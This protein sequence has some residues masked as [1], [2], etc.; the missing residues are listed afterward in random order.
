V[1]GIVAAA[2]LYSTLIGIPVA[3]CVILFVQIQLDPNLGLGEI[4]G[5]F[6]ADRNSPIWACYE[7]LIH[8]AWLSGHKA[9]LYWMVPLASA[10]LLIPSYFVSVWLEGRVC[11]HAWRQIE[12]GVVSA[13]VT[14]VNRLSYAALFLCACGWLGW[15]L[16][17]H[18]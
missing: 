17:T 8:F 5:Y 16:L 4:P 13:A 10:L 7:V 2:N 6:H 14:H 11:R 15:K 18:A 9:N 1:F 12:P 3:W